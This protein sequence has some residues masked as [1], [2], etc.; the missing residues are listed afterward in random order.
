M[1]KVIFYAS[2]IVCLLSAVANL[3]FFLFFKRKSVSFKEAWLSFPAKYGITWYA[4][5]PQ[6]YYKKEVIKYMRIA[7]YLFYLTFII[8]ASLFLITSVQPVDSFEDNPFGVLAFLSWNHPWNNYMYKSDADLDRA[9][10][11]IKNLGVSIIRLD[12]AWNDIE[13]ERNE[14]D[15][16]R[17]DYIVKACAENNIQILGVLGYSPDWTKAQWNQPPPDPE[18]FIKFVEKTVKRYPQ[19]LYWEIW[20]EPDARTYWQPQDDMKTYTKLLK[21][22][23]SAIKKVN[24]KSLVLL[25]GLTTEGF[26]AFKSVLRQGGGDCFD[27]MNFHAFVGPFRENALEEIGYKIKHIRNELKKFNLNKKIWITEIGCP[28]TPQKTCSWWLGECPD[29]K[30]QAEFLEKIYEFLLSQENV[31]KIFWAFFQDT[32]D[33]FHSGVDKFG[34]I[35]LDYSKKPAYLTYKEIIQKWKNKSGLH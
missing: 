35:R 23:Y 33:H 20:N 32:N 1:V 5:R 16:K 18:L 6:A 11:L 3:V 17:H 12:F 27:I 25:G 29:E 28:G 15:F 14:L 8:T 24:P 7:Y 19:I 10:E 9:I 30:Q 26:Y 21:P 34:L 2:F 31:E 22:A 13:K 4:R